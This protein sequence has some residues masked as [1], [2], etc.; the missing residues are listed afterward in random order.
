[1]WINKKNSPERKYRQQ[2]VRSLRLIILACVIFSTG[3]AQEKTKAAATY[4]PAVFTSLFDGK[5][6]TGWTAVPA[7][8][9]TVADSAIAMTGNARGFI[10][11]KN[12]YTSYR[13][14]FN[15][16]QIKGV[17]HWPCQLIFG[18]DTKLDAMGAVQ[19][20]LPKGYTWDYR[21]G[22]NN[23]GKDYFSLPGHTPNVNK[24]DWARCEILVN[25]SNGSA[26]TAVAQPVGAPAIPATIFKDAQIPNIATAFGLQSHNKGQFDEYKDI[27]IEVNPKIDALLTVLAAPSDLKATKKSSTQIIL[28][29]A[30]NSQVEDGFVVE[31]S[32]DQVHWLDIARL[33]QDATGYTD[34]KLDS[35]NRYYYRVAAFNAAAVSGYTSAVN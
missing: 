15:V 2:T 4:T 5:T 32:T 10:Y 9:W 3:L 35:R 22:K 21:P 13:I 29:W 8:G 34:R 33:G 12:T 19:V 31:R 18:P 27:I 7:D 14:I 28:S 17:D 16:R 6:L 30:D 1:M 11:T 25:A 26:R 20:Q 23:S 24:G